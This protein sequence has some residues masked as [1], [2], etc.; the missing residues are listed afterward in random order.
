MNLTVG[1]V[2]KEARVNIETIRFYE[3][4]SLLPEPPTS[5]SGYRQYSPE[6]VSRICF[7]K[8]SQ[9]LGSSLREISELLYLRVEPGRTCGDVKK[10]SEEKQDGIER[11]MHEFEEMKKALS[12]LASQ[13]RGKGP[14]S[15]C[16]ILEH[17]E[18][19]NTET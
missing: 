14:T 19:E 10:I 1:Q 18:M 7:I 11:K 17:L 6:I 2:A 12:T 15:E 8:R 4:K 5:A 9:E 13:C 16:P 3:R